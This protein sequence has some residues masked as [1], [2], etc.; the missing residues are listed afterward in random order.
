M[1]RSVSLMVVALLAIGCD[2]GQAAP[3]G[4]RPQARGKVDLAAEQAIFD[5][6]RRPDLIV[7]AAGLKPGEVVADVGAGTGLLTVHL[8]RAVTPGGRVVATDINGAV[9]D[10]LAQR[11]RAAGIDG[12]IETRV[13][14]ADVPGLEA[15]AGDRFDV[16]LLAQVD[17]YFADRVAW[18]KAVLPALA[19]TGR[20]VITNRVHHRRAAMAAAAEAGLVLVSETSD[21]PGQFVAVFRP[22]TASPVESSP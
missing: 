19:P 16:I 12:V 6:D 21:V 1:S 7:A 10:M 20:I 8:A 3:T 15:A 18:L 13:V 9:L 4:A 2:P 14:A 22:G 17:H 5:H 11:A